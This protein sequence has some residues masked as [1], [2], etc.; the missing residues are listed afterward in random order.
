MITILAMGQSNALGYDDGPDFSDSSVEVWNC[1]NNVETLAN[2]GTAWVPMA[3]GSRPFRAGNYGNMSAYAAKIIAKI[4]GEPVRLI[5]VAVDGRSIDKW[6]NASNIVGPIYARMQSVLS[7]AGVDAPVDHFMWMQGEQDDA[8]ANTYATRWGYMISR[9]TSN[10]VIDAS[11][12]I[13]IGETSPYFS[14][15]VTV[16][17]GLSG[18]KVK[19][20]ANSGMPRI[21]DNS[22]FT[23]QSLYEAGRQLARAAGYDQNASGGFYAVVQQHSIP[24]GVQAKINFKG[25]LWNDGGLLN[26]VSATATPPIGLWNFNISVQ[27]SGLTVGSWY[28]VNLMKNGQI[29]RR[30]YHWSDKNIAKDS[31]LIDDWASGEDVYEVQV[32]ATGTPIVSADHDSSWWVISPI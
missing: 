28:I 29:H 9:L 31:I 27:C 1:E 22:H 6:V 26:E 4:S 20:I 23:G 15:I 18:G 5:L 14:S 16:L 32:K 2:I 24:N 30:S 3:K 21:T 12:N 8:T 19:V 7:A 25:S 13:I 11:T 17:R 10:G